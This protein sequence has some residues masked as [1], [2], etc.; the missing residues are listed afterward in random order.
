MG[1][2]VYSLRPQHPLCLSY[3]ANREQRV[4]SWRSFAK[5][6]KKKKKSKATL[7]G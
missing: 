6:S 2:Y 3:I 5:D 4:D 1:R 7:L